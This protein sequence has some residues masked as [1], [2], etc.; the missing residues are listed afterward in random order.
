MPII[1]RYGHVPRKDGTLRH[2]PFIPI[3]VKNKFGQ[4]MKVIGLV[5][6]GADNTVVPKD[7]ADLLGIKGDSTTTEIGGIGGKVNVKR[8]RM[9]PSGSWV[10]GKAMHWMCRRLSCR[11]RTMMFLC[12]SEGMDFLSISI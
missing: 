12:F 2:A 9:C 1:Y 7:L 6:S 11:I 3:V 4:A 5:D 8:S 10:N